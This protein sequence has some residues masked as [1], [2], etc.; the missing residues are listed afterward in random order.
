MASN[1]PD[2]MAAR[3]WEEQEAD[4]AGRSSV[5]GK[6]AAERWQSQAT[7]T[8]IAVHHFCRLEGVAT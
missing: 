8:G 1:P 4:S 6:F 3:R 2:A 5:D 7:G